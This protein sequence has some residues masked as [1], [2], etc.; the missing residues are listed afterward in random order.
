MYHNYY[1]TSS[2]E[3]ELIVVISIIACIASIVCLVICALIAALKKRSVGGWIVGGL[4]LG[5]IAVI[6]LVFLPSNAYEPRVGTGNSSHLVKKYQPY[7]CMNCKHTIDTRTCTVCHFSNPDNLL[8]PFQV[9]ESA[10][11]VKRAIT[12]TNK[13]TTVWYCKCGSANDL[14]TNEC[15]SCYAKREYYH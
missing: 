1:G 11:V 3:W 6:I 2:K 9:F 10:P 4:F 7:T 12:R 8:K 13:K 15:T 5:W 14:G